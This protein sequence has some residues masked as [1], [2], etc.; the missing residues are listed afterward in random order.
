MEKY[1]AIFQLDKKDK[2]LISCVLTVVSLDWVA[3]TSQRSAVKLCH[4]FSAPSRVVWESWTWVTTTCGIEEWC[5]YLQEC[6]VHIVDWKHSGQGSSTD[7]HIV[8]YCNILL[9]MLDGWMDFSY[10]PVLGAGALY[11][12]PVWDFYSCYFKASLPK[13]PVCSDF[14]WLYMQQSSSSTCLYSAFLIRAS[15]FINMIWIF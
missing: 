15:V 8:I 12:P 1:T 14:F 4:Q 3:G 9:S 6:R 5:C 13:S 2:D 11:A 10:C 7:E